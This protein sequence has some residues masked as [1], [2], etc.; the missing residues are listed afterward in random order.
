MFFL[1][2]AVPGKNGK[3][4]AD[5]LWTDESYRIKLTQRGREHANSNNITIGSKVS[6]TYF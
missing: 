4:K 2:F 6:I 3:A 1:L 5:E